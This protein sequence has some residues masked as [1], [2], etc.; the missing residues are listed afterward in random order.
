MGSNLR[1]P[2]GFLGGS[3]CG[4]KVFMLDIF[5][6]EGTNELDSFT[7]HSCRAGFKPQFDELVLV[8]TAEVAPSRYVVF[9]D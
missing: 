2:W 8:T 9:L 7:D 6:G 3:R 5:M 4:R 1:A